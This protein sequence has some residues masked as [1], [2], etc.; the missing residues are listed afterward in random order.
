MSGESTSSGG[1]GSGSGGGESTQAPTT[2][3]AE[4]SS[5]GG[6]EE[7]GAASTSGGEDVDCLVGDLQVAPPPVRVDGAQAVPID[8]LELDA[9]LVV[10]VATQTTEVSAMLRFV[11]GE[12]G[13]PIFDLRQSSITEVKL[14]GVAID[15]GLMPERDLGGGP[16][17]EMR[18]LGVAL[19]ACSEHTL[20]L[21]YPLTMLPGIAAPPPSF[22]SDG[23]TW[24]FG[25]SD[26][27]PRMFLEQWLPANLI[28][29]RHSIA[30]TVEVLGAPEEQR[31]ISNGEVSE[32]GPARWSIDFPEY[33]T[34]QSTML[35]LTPA[36]RVESSSQMIMAQD[37]PAVAV[38]LHRTIETPESSAQLHQL[39]AD[40]F[41]EFSDSTGEYAYPRFTAYVAINEGMEYDGGTTSAVYALPHELFHS[42]YGRGARPMHARDGWIDEAWDEWNTGVPMFPETGLDMNDPP[43]RLYDP[44]PWGRTT[45]LAAYEDGKLLF[46]GVAA[47]AGAQALRDAMR[48]FYAAH[49]LGQMTTPGLEQHLTCTLAAPAL[50]SLFHR[51]VYGLQGAP[52]AMPDGYCP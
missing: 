27:A 7:S 33:S 19:A 32:L 41:L 40:A 5:S 3:A 21:R 20:E 24:D 11:I 26:L 9:E 46:S 30:L 36:S 10:D 35:V 42:W 15:P 49:T 48:E 8:V 50:R 25:F 23:V 51:F 52:E 22:A 18:V 16:G 39:L 38:E 45:P 29:D 17:R 34:A 43:V 37:G 6:S 47:I 13:R 44:N 28:H 12:A 14:D 31:L 2:G 4:T 1:S